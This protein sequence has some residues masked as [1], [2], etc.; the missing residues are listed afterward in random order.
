MLGGEAPD[1]AGR[2]EEDDV[3]IAAIGH[4]ST[5][6]RPARPRVRTA[7]S[8]DAPLLQHL[9][10][11]RLHEQV[12]GEESGAVASGAS[13]EPLRTRHTDVSTDVD[14]PDDVETTNSR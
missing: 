8:G 12:V 9:G 2:A 5:V 1:E 4:G 7:V 10:R 13:A 14:G 3:E 6:P 11:A